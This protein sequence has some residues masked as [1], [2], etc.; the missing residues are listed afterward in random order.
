M[1]GRLERLAGPARVD[2]QGAV[3]AA[4]PTRGSFGG[5]RGG[6]GAAGAVAAVEFVDG[7]GLVGDRRI[8]A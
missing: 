3:A 2:G 7:A 8:P 6:V 5:A 1:S 4:G